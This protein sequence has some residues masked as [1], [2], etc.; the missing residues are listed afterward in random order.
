MLFGRDL[1]VDRIGNELGVD[2]LEILLTSHGRR[3]IETIALYD[4][5][6]AN[7]DC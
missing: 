1:T 4:K 3:S 6:K 7:W 2:P 5:S